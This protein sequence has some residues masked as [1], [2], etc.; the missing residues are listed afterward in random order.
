MRVAEIETPYCARPEGSVSKLNTW[1]DD[2]RILL[3]I[4]QLYRA[5]R[6]MAFFGM[7]GAV[8]IAVSLL[9]G[10][11]IVVTYLQ[12]GLVPRLP[13]AIPDDP[14]LPVDRQRFHP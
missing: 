12:I 7:V 9:L 6:P 10:I 5:E 2:L 14:R 8:L 1:R 4:L 11:P 3:T 13:T